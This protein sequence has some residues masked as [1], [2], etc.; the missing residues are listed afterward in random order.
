MSEPRNPSGPTQ[1]QG[2]HR[3]PSSPVSARSGPCLPEEARTA[4]GTSVISSTCQHGATLTPTSCNRPTSSRRRPPL[5]AGSIHLRTGLRHRRD[6]LHRKGGHPIHPG[7]RRQKAG[8][9]GYRTRGAIAAEPGAT[10]GADARKPRRRRATRQRPARRTGACGSAACGGR[11]RAGPVRCS[12]SAVAA[13]NGNLSSRR[14][15]AA[16]NV[17]V[18]RSGSLTGQRPGGRP[19]QLRPA[20]RGTPVRHAHRLGPPAAHALARRQ[21]VPRSSPSVCPAHPRV[22]R[23]RR[24]RRA[25]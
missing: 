7:P 6:G 13:D 3:R 19:G 14:R 20:R 21:T 2:R 1:P 23:Q 15:A 10:T 5:Q 25:R 12:Y 17:I 16:V 22:Q 18:Y 11:T 8:S 9:C 24:D 4:S